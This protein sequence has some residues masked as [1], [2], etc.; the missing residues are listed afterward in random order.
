MCYNKFNV[1]VVRYN[2]VTITGVEMDFKYTSDYDL[3]FE[4]DITTTDQM[5]SDSQMLDVRLAGTNPEFKHSPSLCV[6]FEDFAGYPNIS[7]VGSLIKKRIQSKLSDDG[8]FDPSLLEIDVYPVDINKVRC[9]VKYTCVV[10][11]TKQSTKESA[12]VEL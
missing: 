8:R 6:S 11:G 9:D 1:N 5:E 12:V 10:N 3:I 2:I 7:S 4:K